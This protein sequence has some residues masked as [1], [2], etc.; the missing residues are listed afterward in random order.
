MVYFG[1]VQNGKIIPEPGAQL[2][3]GS[4]VRIEP[5]T[6]DG[7]DAAAGADPADDLSRFAVPTGIRDLASQHDHYCSGAPK[8]KG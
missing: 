3:E 7:N 6:A 8:R 4:T 2:A 5:V 1:T